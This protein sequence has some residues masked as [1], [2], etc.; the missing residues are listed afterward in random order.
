MRDVRCGCSLATED[1]LTQIGG[2]NPVAALRRP[3]GNAQTHVATTRDLMNPRVTESSDGSDSIRTRDE[4]RCPK[5]PQPAPEC[6]I[7][8]E[9]RKTNPFLDLLVQPS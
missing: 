9:M 7:S 2:T 5:M 3:R 6:P 8:C 1:A 4:R